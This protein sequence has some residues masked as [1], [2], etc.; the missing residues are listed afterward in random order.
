MI[1]TKGFTL[2]ELMIVVA[3]IGILSLMAMPYYTTYTKKARVSEALNLFTPIKIATIENHVTSG[4]AAAN[5]FLGLGFPRS[6][7]Y[8]N[9][10]KQ[11]AMI[12]PLKYINMETATYS[13]ITD[14]VNR[15]TLIFDEKF[16]KVHNELVVEMYPDQFD[17]KT[18]EAIR[19]TYKTVCVSY[20]KTRPLTAIQVQF[21]PK[22]CK[23]SNI[24]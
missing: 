8:N 22:P 1:I 15:F 13:G 17:E 3:I 14:K 7:L 23:A 10:P 9:N 24:R 6:A 16:D 19:Q 4:V 20:L 12:S 18:G 11:L 2:I 5:D 21:L